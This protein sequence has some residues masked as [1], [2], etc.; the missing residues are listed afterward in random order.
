MP[1]VQFGLVVESEPRRFLWIVWTK[2]ASEASISLVALVSRSHVVPIP[3]LLVIYLA[4]PSRVRLFPPVQPQK[5]EDICMAFP[6]VGHQREQ[7]GG[8]FLI[9]RCTFC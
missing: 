6:P 2:A 3:D 1:P 8:E 9:V 5:V 4:V 7:V